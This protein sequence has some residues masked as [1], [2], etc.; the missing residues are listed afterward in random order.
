MSDVVRTVSSASLLLAQ[1]N[2]FCDRSAFAGEDRADLVQFALLPQSI[3]DRYRC[4]RHALFL[5]PSVEVKEQE[6]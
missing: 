6:L 3:F 5:Q 2:L 4:A 1:Q